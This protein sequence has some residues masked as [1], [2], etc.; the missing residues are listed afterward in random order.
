M[1]PIADESPKGFIPFVN[2]I[3]LTI[4][5]FVY[6]FIQPSDLHAAELFFAHFG[7]IPTEL[8]SGATMAKGIINIF[9]SMFLHGGFWHLAS[10]MLYLWIFGD[11][12][13]YTMGHGRY[14]IFF[15]TV[16]IGAALLQVVMNPSSTIPMIGASGAISGVLG[17]YLLKF[18]RNRIS[19]LFFFFFIIR[20]VQIPAIIVLSLWFLFQIY[21]SF[22]SLIPG[23]A[24]GGVAYFAHIG[25]FLSGFLL[26]KVFERRSRFY[27]K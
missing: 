6:F 7:L 4:N 22:F 16:G 8:T 23:A 2:Y 14:L 24:G 1:I 3:F 18:P 25:G 26:I 20:I 19:V 11:N 10:N 9:T 5:I 12:V 17:A 27:F 15:L 13:E 21:N